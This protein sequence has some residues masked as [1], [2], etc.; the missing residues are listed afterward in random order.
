MRITRIAARNRS[1]AQAFYEGLLLETPTTEF[2][3]ADA[4]DAACVITLEL[5][6]IDDALEFVWANG[7]RILNPEPIEDGEKC[8]VS[9]VDPE[10]NRVVLIGPRQARLED[11]L[12]TDRR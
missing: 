7:G 9:I 12:D 2:E 3:V 8:F 10:G 1:R 6:S 11:Q 5:A 4:N